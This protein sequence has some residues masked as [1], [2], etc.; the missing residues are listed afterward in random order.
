[1]IDMVEHKLY[2]REKRL[3]RFLKK[4]A[5]GNT[6]SQN[7]RNHV[8]RAAPEIRLLPVN[9]RRWKKIQDEYVPQTERR[10]AGFRFGIADLL[11]STEGA[12]GNATTNANWGRDAVMNNNH[13]NRM[14]V[15]KTPSP[16]SRKRRGATPMQM[17]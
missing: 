10:A 3:L 6:I 2:K 12:A 11:R 14:N 13:D 8:R 15:N 7:L 16:V 1:M 17:G 4:K 5:A 9:L